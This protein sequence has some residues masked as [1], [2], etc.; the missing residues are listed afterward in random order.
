MNTDNY[1]NDY[2]DND[3]FDMTNDFITDSF[4]MN[5]TID[6]LDTIDRQIL[7]DQSFLSSDPVNKFYDKMMSMMI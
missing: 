3:F 7:N 1:I 2:I 5:P 4:F 6:N